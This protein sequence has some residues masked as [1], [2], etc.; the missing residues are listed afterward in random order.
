MVKLAALVDLASFWGEE[1]QCQPR[2]GDAG[3][4]GLDDPPFG[5]HRDTSSLGPLQLPGTVGRVAVWWDFLLKN[6]FFLMWI[7]FLKS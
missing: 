3:G 6:F 7:T 2:A 5:D 4:L 1:L